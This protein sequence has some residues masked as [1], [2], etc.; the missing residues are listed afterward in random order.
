M[1]KSV[2]IHIF[3]VLFLD[4]NT[5]YTCQ[6]EKGAKGNRPKKSCVTS[7][8]KKEAKV[9]Q[10]PCG[11][12]CEGMV[13]ACEEWW[14]RVRNGGCVRG[15][16]AACEGW[17]MRLKGWRMR[18]KRAERYKLSRRRSAPGFVSKFTAHFHKTMQKACVR[19]LG[20]LCRHA[21]RG[22]EY[23][24]ELDYRLLFSYKVGQMR[25]DCR[26]RHELLRHAM[27][28]ARRLSVSLRTASARNDRCE[29]IVGVAMNSA[30]TRGSG[31]AVVG[32]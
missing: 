30:S 19:F 10:K 16:V 3:S 20:D 26:Y 21:K 25:G 14:L 31:H 12:P 24:R 29:A 2:F 28:D 4:S 15:M 5:V 32:A 18:W 9:G 13:A 11:V 22:E 8:R 6:M 17:H 27:T 23:L 1:A 7:F